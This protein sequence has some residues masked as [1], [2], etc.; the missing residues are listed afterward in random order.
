[1]SRT[2]FIRGHGGAAIRF[3]KKGILFRVRPLSFY[4]ELGARGEAAVKAPVLFAEFRH[5]LRPAGEFRTATLEG[6]TSVPGLGAVV[7]DPATRVLVLEKTANNPYS[8]LIFVGRSA[9]CDVVIRDS[10]VSKAHAVFM[11][12]KDGFHVLDNRSHNGTFVNG[13]RLGLAERVKVKT[14]DCLLFGA[15]PVYVVMPEDLPQVI[16]Q[17]GGR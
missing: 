9:T 6:E 15:Y 17:A 14:G 1:M 13:R 12:D 2:P 16:A 11:R 3:Q 10:S 8:E 5:A 7:G 4:R